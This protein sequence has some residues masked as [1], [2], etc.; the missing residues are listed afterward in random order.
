MD[1]RPSKTALKKE[2]LELQ[3]LG[4]KLVALSLDQLKQ[5]KLSDNLF[6]AI[7]EAKELTKFGA[8][9]RQLQYIGR[10]MREVDPKP[11][12]AGVE[13]WDKKSGQVSVQFHLIE[14]WRRR[15]LENDAALAEFVQAYAGANVHHLRT[16]VQRVKSERLTNQPSKYY[17]M[18]FKELQRLMR[19]PVS[20][21]PENDQPE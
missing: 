8:L 17:R 10:L 14:S 19:E 18:L 6:D 4:E 11:I 15:L 5:L 2:M 7:I 9:R 20:R 21:A 13:I 1:D 3:D 16:L 12:K